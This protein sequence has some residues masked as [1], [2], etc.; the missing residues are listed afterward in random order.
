M[1]TLK[2]TGQGQGQAIRVETDQN[3]YFTFPYV[4]SNQ[5]Y[6]L[7][8]AVPRFSP[9]I[10]GVQVNQK[11]VDLANLVL[12]PPQPVG[13][14]GR[15]IDY[16]GAPVL[17]TILTLHR[18]GENDITTRADQD[19]KFS[20]APVPSNQRYSLHLE[21]AGLNTTSIDL[22]V[23]ERN[24]EL[25]TVIVQPPRP[26]PPTSDPA[27]LRPFNVP[28]RDARISGRI[29]DANGVPYADTALYLRDLMLVKPSQPEAVALST[30]VTDRN[31]MF[32]FPASSGHEYEAYLPESRTPLT[33]KG[34]GYIVAAGGSEVDLGNIAMQVAPTQEP[35]GKLVG[36]VKVSRFPSMSRSTATP[37]Q[38]SS[39]FAG[40]GRVL[41]IIQSDG[42]VLQQPKEKDQV[43]CSS[44]RLSEDH[45][46]VGW[47]VDSDFCCT[48][49]PIQLILVVYRPGKPLQHFMATAGQSFS[50][51]SSRGESRSRFTRI[52]FTEHRDS[53]TNYETWIRAA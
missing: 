18:D 6:D 31:G 25:G 38:I 9:W 4:R 42:Q 26:M 32:V 41:T 52:F 45:R 48:S 11:D 39:L 40:A 24:I 8:I 23:E 47:L 51:S 37:V 27:A 2:I 17:N 5:H 50:G 7:I 21:A 29:T 19:G 34:L 22:D 13:I 15:L 30:L 49:Y 10:M 33:Y 20:L 44:L 16:A 53:T 35:V 14:S 43:G 46:T 1:I 12:Q 36:P 28:E 3:G